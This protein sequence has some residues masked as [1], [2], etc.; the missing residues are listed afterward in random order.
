MEFCILEFMGGTWS[1]FWTNI[2]DHFLYNH[3]YKRQILG[4]I[5]TFH[6]LFNPL[7]PDVHYSERRDKL[8]S[9]HNKLRQPMINW[10]IFIFCI[11]G[12]NGLT[13]QPY[14]TEMGHWRSLFFSPCCGVLKKIFDWLHHNDYEHCVMSYEK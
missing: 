10:R 9:L 6:C 7:V 4:H 1:N 3:L 12:T 13:T 5:N 11:P 8:P 2:Q 14:Y